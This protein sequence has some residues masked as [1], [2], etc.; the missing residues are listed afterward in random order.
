MMLFLIL[1]NY[2]YL[3]DLCYI[4]AIEYEEHMQVIGE[5]GDNITHASFG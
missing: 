3:N 5:V 4:S 2:Q 1:L